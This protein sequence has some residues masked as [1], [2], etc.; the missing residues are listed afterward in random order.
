MLEYK[1]GQIQLKLSERRKMKNVLE[2]LKKRKLIEEKLMHLN[3]NCKFKPE[4]RQSREPTNICT[5]L[6]TKSKHF[7]A[8][9]LCVILCK[10]GKCNCN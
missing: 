3:M 9:C 7:I 6:K 10:K 1:T 4:Y 8:R 2:D 5:M